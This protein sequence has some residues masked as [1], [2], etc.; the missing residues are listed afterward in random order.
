MEWASQAAEDW[1]A[2]ELEEEQREEGG[3]DA[4][5]SRVQDLELNADEDFP[6]LLE[7]CCRVAGRQLSFQ[8]VQEGPALFDRDVL[9]RIAY[10]SF[11]CR[12][13]DIRRYIELSSGSPKAARELY[14]SI[15]SLN[16]TS[17]MQIG[18]SRDCIS[19]SR[20]WMHHA[21]SCCYHFGFVAWEG[22]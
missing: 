10:W 13:S 7:L 3:A 5:C 12:Y 6:S 9:S 15:S 4:W 8:L 18:E 1:D 14:Q 22:V 19:G 20:D 11:P 21:H 17:H 16:L 2:E